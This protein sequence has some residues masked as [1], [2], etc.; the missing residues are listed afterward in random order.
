MSNRKRYLRK[1]ADGRFF[2]HIEKPTYSPIS[3]DKKTSLWV[4]SEYL[5]EES[6]REN[7]ESALEQIEKMIDWNKKNE[8][9]ELCSRLVG[10]KAKYF[11]L[12]TKNPN[13][14]G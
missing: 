3:I 12:N 7:P 11:D 6:I 13:S 10:L 2:L 14:F 5:I 8:K 1:S 9:Y 4:S